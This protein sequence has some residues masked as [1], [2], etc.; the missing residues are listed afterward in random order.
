MGIS[1]QTKKLDSNF[2]QANIDSSFHKRHTILILVFFFSLPLPQRAVTLSI[3]ND[4]FSSKSIPIFPSLI[5]C[6]RT[7]Q[8]QISHCICIILKAHS[9]ICWAGKQLLLRCFYFYAWVY[10]PWQQ[11]VDYAGKTQITTLYLL[12]AFNRKVYLCLTLQSLGC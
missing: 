9:E 4:F 3:D 11:R 8:N 5:S 10:C 2:N 1:K 6:P 7:R 12:Y